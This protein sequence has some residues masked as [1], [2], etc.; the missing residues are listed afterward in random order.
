MYMR[1][2][3]W[4]GVCEVQSIV[5]SKNAVCAQSRRDHVLDHPIERCARTHARVCT[6]IR[7]RD[8]EEEGET[9]KGSNEG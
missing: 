9:S 8:D 2:Q 5:E 4:N 6:R 1:T 7:V 3:R